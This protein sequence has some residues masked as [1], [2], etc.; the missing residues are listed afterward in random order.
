MENLI[1]ND[2]G[3]KKRGKLIWG[4]LVYYFSVFELK[5]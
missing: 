4:V 5:L 2:K 1:N 3:V